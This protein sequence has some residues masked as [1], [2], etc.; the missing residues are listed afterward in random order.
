[1][2]YLGEKNPLISDKKQ[3]VKFK[4]LFYSVYVGDGGG[5][6][7]PALILLKRSRQ[8]FYAAIRSD[9]ATFRML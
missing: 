2:F 7:M 9:I 5:S 6:G 3:Q 8:S 4:L 1:M